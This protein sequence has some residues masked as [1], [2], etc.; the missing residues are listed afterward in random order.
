MIKLA[1][2]IAL[3]ICLGAM[4]AVDMPASARREARR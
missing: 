1:R 4:V 2:V 3:I